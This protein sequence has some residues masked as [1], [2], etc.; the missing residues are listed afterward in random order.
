MSGAL[1]AEDDPAVGS[2]LQARLERDR[3]EV[4]AVPNVRDA[5]RC[6]ATKNFDP[7]LSGLHMAN[8]GEFRLADV[9][10]CCLVQRD[11]ELLCQKGGH[12]VC[13][14]DSKQVSAEFLI[15]KLPR[16]S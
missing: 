11:F 12:V 14:F 2:V 10:R 5:L 1:P 15:H 13:V 9:A 3:Y 6:I 8:S 7:V 16:Q 4:V